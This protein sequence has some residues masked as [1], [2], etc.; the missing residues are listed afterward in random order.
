MP[1]TE[2]I[3]PLA[4]EGRTARRALSSR[5]CSHSDSHLAGAQRLS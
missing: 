2:S 3:C 1:K 4:A 5:L